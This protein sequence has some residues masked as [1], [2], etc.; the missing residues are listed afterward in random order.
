MQQFLETEFHGNTYATWLTALVVFAGVFAALILVRW[1]ALRRLADLARRT[2]TDVDDIVVDLLGRTKAFF[3]FAMAL[4]AG[5]A[6]LAVPP[7]SEIIRKVAVAAAVFVQAVI[8]T[9]GLISY[10]VDRMAARQ[11]AGEQANIAVVRALA[12]AAKVVVFIAFFLVALNEVVRITPLIAGL[13]IGGIAV[14]LALQNVLGDLFG[15]VSILV[16]KPFTVGDFVVVDAQKGT[17][18]HIGLKSTRVRSLGGEQ[19]IFSNA[20][21]LKSRIRNFKRMQERRVEFATG[22]VYET[23]LETLKR[24]PSIIREI[25]EAQPQVR[26]ERCHFLRYRDSWLEYETIYWVTV[27]DYMVFADNHQNINLELFRRFGEEGIS[28]AYP[29]STLR[30]GTPADSAS[31]PSHPAMGGLYTSP[32]QEQRDS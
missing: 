9:N 18:E 26:F 25:V 27:Q 10:W 19:I 1:I 7:A 22:V 29:T 16:D 21:L 6:V 24:I 17:V 2:A 3:I 8:W 28:F 31:G 23:P 15:A 30:V 12:G 32:P 4:A 20:D 14:A 11:P 13:G 5:W